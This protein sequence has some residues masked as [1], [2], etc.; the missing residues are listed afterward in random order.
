MNG[1]SRPYAM[2]T[3]LTRPAPTPT[4]SAREDHDARRRSSGSASVVAQTAG[5]R[6]ER[7]DRQV[8]AAA[9]DHEGHA[10]RDHADRPTACAGCSRRLSLVQEDVAGRVTAPT[11]QQDHQH[12]DQAEV[13]HARPSPS[14]AAAA[15]RRARRRASAAARPLR[16]RVVTPAAR[17]ARSLTGSLR[18][19]AALPS[20]TRS[21]TVVLVE[22]VGRRLVDDRPSRI[23]STRSARPS[24]SGTSLETSSTPT[25]VVGQPADDARRARPGR[26]RRRR[27]SARRA[28]AA[29]WPPS[30]QRPSTTFCWLPPDSVRTGRL[31]VRR[32][33]GRALARDSRRASAL[34]AGGRASRAGRTG[35]SVASVMLRVDGSS[36]QQRLA[37]ALLGGQAE[38]G[39]DRGADAARRAAAARPTATVPGV[40]RRAP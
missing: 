2:S 6:D 39:A 14:R 30:S 18:R 17:S 23:T 26:R 22:L 10:D 7:A 13:A 20:M 12:A 8:D 5:Q 4:S 19:S 37:L 1:T 32:A 36:Q 16:R 35:C 31:D 21:S 40:G 25:P 29:W 9:D 24:T 28:A 38:P 34:L 27:G 11:T 33:A 15:R 3:P